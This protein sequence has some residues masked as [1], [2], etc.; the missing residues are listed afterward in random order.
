MGIHRSSQGEGG[1]STSFRAS[2]DEGLE[3][4]F[5]SDTQ[6]LSMRGER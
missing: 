5:G 3:L 4:K 6:A 2:L 1:A